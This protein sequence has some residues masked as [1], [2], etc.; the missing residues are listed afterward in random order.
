[1]KHHYFRILLTMLMSIANAY[2]LAESFSIDG[3]TYEVISSSEVALTSANKNV[4]NVVIPSQVTNGSKNY[5]VVSIGA[6]AFYEC[7]DMTSITLPN[8]IKIIGKEGF[9]RCS[10]LTSITI[11]EGIK[12]IR[13]DTFRGCE[14]LTS[15]IIPKSVETIG[16]RA[17]QACYGLLSITIPD[18]VTTLLDNAFC[19]CSKLST[20]NIGNGLTKIG[21]GAFSGCKELTSVFLP[22]CITFIGNEAFQDCSSLKTINIPN[23]VTTINNKTFSGCNNLSIFP[24]N[25]NV[26]TI[27]SNAFYKCNSFTSLTIPQNVTTIYGYAF[28]GCK[29][30]TSVTILNSEIDLGRAFEECTSLQQV[31]FHCKEIGSSWFCDYETISKI[32]IGKEVN[33]I[34]DNAFYNCRLTDVYCYAESVPHTGSFGFKNVSLENVSLHVPESSIYAYQTTEPWRKFG[35]F[36]ALTE[37]EL[38]IE[39]VRKDDSDV[40]YYQLNGLKSFKPKHGLNIIRAKD[41][42]TKK[43]LVR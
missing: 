37:Q 32:I 20:I 10:S 36:V 3:I 18:N 14:S 21:T 29:G 16:N 22:D 27:G 34:K 5:D 41:G 2:V 12:E 26:T 38:S 13:D 6:K 40:E 43:V 1:M 11:P 35:K 42:K 17:F 24:I 19:N 23:G 25:E 4:I 28:Y 8:T 33:T 30:L 15:F 39:S 7:R 31:E 9:R